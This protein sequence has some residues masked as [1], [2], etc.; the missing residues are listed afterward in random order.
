M[1]DLVYSNQSHT[2]QTYIFPAG[3][4]STTNGIFPD[5]TIGS[6]RVYCKIKKATDTSI[7]V[8]EAN[9]WSGWYLILWYR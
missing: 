6:A 5:F 3:K 1:A 9:S 8:S 2:R 4:L 7:T